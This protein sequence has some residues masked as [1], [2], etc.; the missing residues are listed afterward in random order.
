MLI[1]SL[2]VLLLFL[3]KISYIKG[4]IGC[5]CSGFQHHATKWHTCPECMNESIPGD[6]GCINAFS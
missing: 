4:G 2:R 6:P 5:N 3:I 1:I